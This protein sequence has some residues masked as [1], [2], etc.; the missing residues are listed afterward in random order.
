MF[1]NSNIFVILISHVNMH[2]GLRLGL[3]L[4]ASCCEWQHLG[5]TNM[6]W[7]TRSIRRVCQEIIHAKIFWSYIDSLIIRYEFIIQIILTF[8]FLWQI[9]L[10]PMAIDILSTWFYTWMIFSESLTFKSYQCIQVDP[11]SPHYYGCCALRA[12]T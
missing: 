8:I 7:S 3:C 11:T 1:I 5:P 9:Q 12:Q 6:N 4:K 10:N 2:L